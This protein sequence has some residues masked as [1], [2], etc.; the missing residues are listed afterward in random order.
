M[1][2]LDSSRRRPIGGVTP[3]PS[4]SP[5]P[6]PVFTDDDSEAEL[7]DQVLDRRRR[8][9]APP[10]TISR[11]SVTLN[12]P[13]NASPSRD[14]IRTFLCEKLSA[15]FE[16]EEWTLLAV[17]WRP[18]ITED[19]N[20]QAQALFGNVGSVS[21]ASIPPT[22]EASF[23]ASF[24]PRGKQRGSG[25]TSSANLPLSSSTLEG[26]NFV[27]VAS[28]NDPDGTLKVLDLGKLLAGDSGIQGGANIFQLNTK[29][30]IYILRAT[31]AK[32]RQQIVT[33]LK[34]VTDKDVG[35][36]SGG[37][38]LGSQASK[39][40]PVSAA[41]LLSK[42][43]QVFQDN[44]THLSK[45]ES[46]LDSRATSLNE[47]IEELRDF[48]TQ[49]GQLARDVRTAE[50]TNE[51]L[52]TRLGE[53]ESKANEAS[54]RLEVLQTRVFGKLEAMMN[55]DTLVQLEER[56]ARARQ[57]TERRGVVVNRAVPI[58]GSDRR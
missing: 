10:K 31:S 44:S 8:A 28:S 43:E 33:L 11:T 54:K 18:V 12:L 15:A 25:S 4:P 58:G 52:V 17:A 6:E 36:G 29:R 5:S 53:M 22:L 26:L 2:S 49:R 55:T 3:S 19:N 16:P 41:R 37:S 24:D 32:E 23:R 34:L 27:E 57:S 39:D 30:G 7:P 9:D 46:D 50:R 48:E 51:E 40:K 35:G 21:V 38:L 20:F 13:Q 45:L 56:L 42:I 47:L 1:S 14:L